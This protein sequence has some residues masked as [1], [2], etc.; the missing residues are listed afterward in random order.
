MSMPTLL[1]LEPDPVLAAALI[2]QIEQAKLAEVV[3]VDDL[4]A[5]LNALHAQDFQ[6]VVCEHVLGAQSGL[7]LLEAMRSEDRLAELPFVLLSGGL[8][9]AAAQQAIRLGI[10]DLLIKPFT[11]Q[12]LLERIARV[13]Q[14]DRPPT[15]QHNEQGETRASILV[16][17]D[18]PDNLQLLAGLFRDQFKVKLA[19]NG[20]KALAICQS[21]APPDLILLDVMMPGMDG[22]EVARR[23]RQHHASEYTPIIFVTALSD[24]RSRE[25]G[26]ALG[27]VDYV[28]KPIDPAL[29]R[30]RVRNLMRYVEHQRQLQQHFDQ[31]L[32]LAALQADM[33]RLIGHDLRQ[34]L[35][36]FRPALQALSGDGALSAAQRQQVDQL[37]HAHTQVQELIALASSQ[38]ALESGQYKPRSEA[39]ALAPLL[40]ELCAQF[41]NRHA[42][43]ALVLHLE[44]TLTGSADTLAVQADPALCHALLYRLLHYACECSPADSRIELSLRDG[45]P[46]QLFLQLPQRPA[47]P[48]PL[49]AAHTLAR[50]QGGELRQDEGDDAQAYRLELRLPRAMPTT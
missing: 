35:A 3:A 32:E 12:K 39:L 41:R 27:A 20:E 19:H 47:H 1:L 49:S 9:R 10:G 31:M 45:D 26:L 43:R 28:S 18:T 14:R 44:T 37:D 42:T 25:Q 22:F 38:L 17:D 24:A 13:L 8:D 15:A 7:A 29:L 6:L 5:A 50:T 46:I 33:L 48:N 40:T 21:D 30:I 34:P 2:G 23:L 16:V 4:D 36:S 11:S